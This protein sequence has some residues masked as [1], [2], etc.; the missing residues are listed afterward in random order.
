MYN[1]SHWFVYVKTTKENGM[2]KSLMCA[3]CVMLVAISAFTC[4]CIH[5]F[6]SPSNVIR[7]AQLAGQVAAI[8]WV[9]IDNPSAADKATAVKIISLVQTNASKVKAGESYYTILYPVVATWVSNNVAAQ[10]QAL[11]FRAGGS[12]LIGVDTFFAVNPKYAADA[13]LVASGVDAFCTGAKSGL[14][15]TSKPAVSQRI[16]TNAAV[17]QKV[18][19]YLQKK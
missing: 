1:V 14:S 11:A 7:D 2:K 5:W 4:G 16:E 15:Y 3:V 19:A 12:I 18:V 9:N 17:R 10:S 6:D 13:T 8:A